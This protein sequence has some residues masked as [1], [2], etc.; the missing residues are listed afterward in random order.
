[1]AMQNRWM[2]RV[3]EYVDG[4]LDLAEREL[5]E[6]RLNEDPDL[7][8][9]VEEVED[10]V[11]RAASLGPIE[12][13]QDLWA[14]IEAR[15]SGGAQR[16]HAPQSPAPRPK[17]IKRMTLIAAGLAVMV[18]SGSAGWWLHGI[19]TPTPQNVAGIER[20]AFEAPTRDASAANFADQEERLAEN[21]TDLEEILLQ[22]GE[23]LDPDTR[24][25]IVENLRLIDSAIADAHRALQD[26]PNSDFLHANITNSMERKVRLLEDAARLASKEI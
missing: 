15:I 14:G 2:E 5:F 22:Y 17:W 26:D 1:M 6:D 9:A 8:Q 3:S 16:T 18:I 20:P 24:E 4:E 12:P 13:S 23:R 19:G 10:L 21:I 25:A 7:R 11:A